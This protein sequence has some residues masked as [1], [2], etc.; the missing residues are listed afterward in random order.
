M[1]IQSIDS[2]PPRADLK[3]GAE[4][5]VAQPAARAPATVVETPVAVAKSAP[6]PSLEQ[7]T[8]A[9]SNINKSL[10]TLS[11]DVVF[12]IDAD[13]NRTIVKVVD[14]KTKEVIRQIPTEE[15]LEI[16]KA[17]DSASALDTVKGLLIKQKA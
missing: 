17:L 10:Q 14:Q 16:A 12:S 8:H 7:L 13:S 3:I 11:Q 9:V 1:A 4:A 2:T 6:A 5:A 15:T